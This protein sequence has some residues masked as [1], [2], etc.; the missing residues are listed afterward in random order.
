MTFA[1]RHKTACY[2]LGPVVLT[3]HN[4]ATARA[5]VNQTTSQWEVDLHFSNDD[6]VTK[7]AQP[8]VNQEV[9]IVLDA[10]VESVPTINAGITGR[11]ITFSGD[12]DE[13]TARA[14]AKKLS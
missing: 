11:D 5:V 13:A 10:V 9:A 4:I 1:D 7:V 14:I 2:A 12:F 3:G 8:Y 6:F